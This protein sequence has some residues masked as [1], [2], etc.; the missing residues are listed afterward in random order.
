MLDY[1][2]K[3]MGP[4]TAVEKQY[5]IERMRIKIQMK[6]KDCLI[7]GCANCHLQTQHTFTLS[8]TPL[9]RK[10]MIMLMSPFSAIHVDK[11]HFVFIFNVPPLLAFIRENRS[12]YFERKLDERKKERSEIVHCES[13]EAT[14]SS[15]R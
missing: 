1:G 15:T 6:R 7:D 11:A 2:G 10:T 5:N 13:L 3:V 12:R 9:W 4:K 8:N 14:R